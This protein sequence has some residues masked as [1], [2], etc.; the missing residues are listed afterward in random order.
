MTSKHMLFVFCCLLVLSLF[1]LSGKSSEHRALAIDD[2]NFDVNALKGK[3]LLKGAKKVDMIDLTW[4]VEMVAVDVL[5]LHTAEVYL[6][7]LDD[8]DGD[9][10]EE[11]VECLRMSNDE[12]VC[13]EVK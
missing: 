3:K 11:E 8:E 12:E 10:D 4:Q 1:L 9:V 6:P 7:S 5:D 2:V 13:L